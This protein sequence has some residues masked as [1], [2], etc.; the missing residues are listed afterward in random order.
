MFGLNIIDVIHRPYET[1][2]RFQPRDERRSVRIKAERRN[3]L[4]EAVFGVYPRQRDAAYIAKGY[5]D[6]ILPKELTAK[7]RF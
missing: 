6:I 2:Q 1:D 4:V 3:G 7:R 5:K